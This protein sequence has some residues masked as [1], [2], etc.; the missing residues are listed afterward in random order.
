M[1]EDFSVGDAVAYHDGTI[2]VTLTCQV[3]KVMPAER[4]VRS[5]HIRDL[6]ELF[7]RCVRGDTLTRIAPVPADGI[8]K[9]KGDAS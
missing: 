4:S 3:V 2:G 9:S 5:Y 7:E 8:F 1:S 6:S